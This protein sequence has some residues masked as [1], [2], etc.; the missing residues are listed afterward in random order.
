[1]KSNKPVQL[2]RGRDQFVADTMDY[3]GLAQV[4]QLQGRVKG[5][6]IPDRAK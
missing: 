4:M 1:M 5:T 2:T 6:L 3:D